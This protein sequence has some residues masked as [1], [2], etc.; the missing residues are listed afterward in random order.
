MDRSI[1][2]KLNKEAHGLYRILCELGE[3]SSVSVVTMEYHAVADMEAGN[4]TKL[5]RAYRNNEEIYAHILESWRNYLI[6]SIQIMKLEETTAEPSDL[7]KS[8]D[9]VR[10]ES[11]EY[12]K[13]LLGNEFDEID[14]A[15][16]HPAY[17]S[18]YRTVWK[19]HQ[20]EREA[21][22]FND[23]WCGTCEERDFFSYLESSPEYLEKQKELSEETKKREAAQVG[24]FVQYIATIEKS[25]DM[26]PEERIELLKK[27]AQGDENAF[28]VVRQGAKQFILHCAMQQ[29]E[30][31]SKTPQNYFTLFEIIKMA[32][33][34][35]TL[36][37][38]YILN[39][40]RIPD[41]FDDFIQSSFKLPLRKVETDAG[42]LS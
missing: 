10:R 16:S 2:E 40:G 23:H 27:I 32:E 37:L 17:P 31:Y 42:M 7:L 9:E 8:K 28:Q 24:E 41:D 26:P 19:R 11:E 30:R 4:I 33:D 38:R 12:F 3:G 25:S 6:L 36:Q 15:W 39:D 29:Y 35:F 21:S 22:P 13:S 1:I 20:K 5:R 14:R 18:V 34:F